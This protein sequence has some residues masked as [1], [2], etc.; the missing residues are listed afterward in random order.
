LG[1]TDHLPPVPKWTRWIRFEQ[2][3][4]EKNCFRQYGITVDR[5]LLDEWVVTC[6]WRRI[7]GRQRMRAIYFDSRNEALVLAEKIAHRRLS[8]GY[9]VSAFE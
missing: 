9:Q 8:R 5:N 7:G 1:V 3:V 4:P 6:S 2:I